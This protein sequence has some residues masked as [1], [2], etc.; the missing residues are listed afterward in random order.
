MSIYT[1]F[2]MNKTPL[3]TSWISNY[4]NMY[5]ELFGLVLELVFSLRM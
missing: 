3:K 4:T 2:I 1:P 5:M